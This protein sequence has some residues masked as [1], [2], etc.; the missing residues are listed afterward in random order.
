MPNVENLTYSEIAA[1][2]SRMMAQH[3]VKTQSLANEII[4]RVYASGNPSAIDS[5]RVELSKLESLSN[6]LNNRSTENVSN[7]GLKGKITVSQA[8]AQL[9]SYNSALTKKAAELRIRRA[10]YSGIIPHELNGRIIYL[11]PTNL[12]DIP[13]LASPKGR[14]KQNPTPDLTGDMNFEKY[15]SLRNSGMPRKDIIK[16]NPALSKLSTAFERSYKKYRSS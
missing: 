7:D 2:A 16:A 10:I 1:Q 4:E 9:R 8:A 13:N 14:A 3:R 5:L 11:D 6:S 15:V 12:Q